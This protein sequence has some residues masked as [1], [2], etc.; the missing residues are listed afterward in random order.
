MNRSPHMSF[1]IGTDCSRNP[2]LTETSK[3]GFTSLIHL[4]GK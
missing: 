2:I 1:G 3:E 4:S